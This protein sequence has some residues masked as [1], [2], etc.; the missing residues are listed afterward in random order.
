M[1]SNTITRE[2]QNDTISN[3]GAGDD[4][5]GSRGSQVKIN[6]GA[7]KN[8]I[9]SNGNSV[10]ITGGNGND[11]IVNGGSSVNINAGSDNDTVTNSGSNVSIE[12]GK[13]KDSIFNEGDNVSISGGEGKDYIMV[14]GL[15]VTVAGGEGNDRVMRGAEGINTAYV[16]TAGNDTLDNFGYVNAI[17]LDSVKVSSSV[18]S[19]DTV[20]LNLSN[21]N[22]LTLINYRSTKVNLVTST[23]KIQKTTSTYNDESETVIFGTKSNDYICNEGD[24]V[25]VDAGAGHDYILNVGTNDVSVAGGAGNDEIYNTEAACNDTLDGGAGDDYIFNDGEDVSINGGCRRRRQ[26]HNLRL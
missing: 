4:S 21:K 8:T 12:G 7:G 25:T 24:S 9:S 16:Y 17:V 10:T 2:K 13:G 14:D 5:I 20:K 26:G 19:G 11:N 3:G 15:N 1:V 23:K 18:R 22:S 6:A